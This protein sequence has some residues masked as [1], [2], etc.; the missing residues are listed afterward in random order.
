MT[1]LALAF[2]TIMEFFFNG[3]AFARTTCLML[4][5]ACCATPASHPDWAALRTQIQATLHVSRPLPNLEEK[6]YG[7]FSPAS[8]VEADRVSY[9]TAYELRVP[10]IVYHPAGATLT[11]HP[12]LVIVNGHGGDKSSWYAYWA[13]ILYARAGAVVLTYDP[14]GEYE[15]NKERRS[16]TRQHDA[17]VQPEEE[18]GRRLQGLMVTDVMQA[19]NY[20]ANRKDVDSK[21]IA[22]LGFSM[23]SL[24]S[25]LSCAVD[26]DIHACVLVG[27]GNL[28]GPGGRWD[29]KSA[30]M[31]ER[32]P[33]QSLK[34][35]GD[36]GAVLFALNAKR[37][38]TLVYNGTADD[39]VDIVHHGPD[40]FEDLRKRT[41][42]ELGSSKDVFDF[43]IF[44][45]DGTCP[46]LFDQ[47]RRALARGEREVSQLD[48]EAD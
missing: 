47:A 33:Y 23:G 22:V 8:G 36:R 31:C 39:V 3:K 17:V 12:A 42:A 25:S 48:K 14:I 43:R 16:E 26:T 30:E 5:I 27:G 11:K 32:I 7:K 41:I 34:G 40:F 2:D 18:M 9:A 20:L 1:F 44:K 6:A 38:P 4:V 37:G 10:S 35:L 46:L 24:V 45:R 19:V 13:G 21:R 29:T 15:R 28:D